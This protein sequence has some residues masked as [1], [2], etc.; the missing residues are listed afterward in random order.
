MDSR[1]PILGDYDLAGPDSITELKRDT[2]WRID[3]PSGQW[4]IAKRPI[5]DPESLRVE[6]FEAASRLMTELHDAGQPWVHPKRNKDGH[7]ITVRD[8][9]LY[10]VTSF[11]EGENTWEVETSGMLPDVGR[12]MGAYHRYQETSFDAQLPV[13]DF[14]EMTLNGLENRRQE[15][16]TFDADRKPPIEAID[17]AIDRFQANTPRLMTLPSGLIHMDLGLTSLLI[18]VQLVPETVESAWSIP[19]PPPAQRC[20]RDLQV[21]ACT[22]LQGVIRDSKDRDN[23]LVIRVRGFRTRQVRDRVSIPVVRDR[24]SIPVVRDR[25]STQVVR[26]RDSILVDRDRDRDSILVDRDRDSILVVRGFRTHQVE[27]SQVFR[28]PPVAINQDSR[29]RANPEVRW[30]RVGSTSR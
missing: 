3:H 6:R 22:C 16:L 23:I 30:A 12:A 2:V 13:H 1:T 27:G 28:I 17:E 19:T 26:D 5:Y 25:V 4:V 20:R 9:S 7:Y 8:G 24:V 10:Q 21:R 15:L 14:I 29:T 18:T 11:D